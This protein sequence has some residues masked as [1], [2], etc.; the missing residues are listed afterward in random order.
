MRITTWACVV[1]MI[2][3]HTIDME[4]T[5]YYVGNHSENESFPPMRFCIKNFGIDSAE[6][7]SRIIM[8]TYFWFALM[9]Q[10]KKSWFYFLVLA[11]ALYWTAMIGW[12]FGLHLVGWPLPKE[13]MPY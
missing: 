9:N 13:V 7:I 5:R 12:M 1:L 2:V 4:L 11:T 6:W 3:I 8:Y 10:E